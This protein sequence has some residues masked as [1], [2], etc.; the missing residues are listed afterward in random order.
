MDENTG[1]IILIDPLNPLGGAYTEDEIKE[2][3]KSLKIMIY[4]IA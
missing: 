3:A 4:F 2:F 1:L